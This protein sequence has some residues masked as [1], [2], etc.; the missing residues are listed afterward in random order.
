MCGYGISMS[1]EKRVI[2]DMEVYNNRLCVLLSNWYIWYWM[3][4]YNLFY[5]TTDNLNYV[6]KDKLGLISRRDILLIFWK[7]KIDVWSWDENNNS[8]VIYTQT[9]VIWVHN[10][11]SFWEYEGSICFISSEAEPR[12]LAI[13]INNKVLLTQGSFSGIGCLKILNI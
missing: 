5:L 11:Y 10:K 2:A 6:G 1:D 9:K 13:T 3:D 4:W 7:N 8:L 12:L